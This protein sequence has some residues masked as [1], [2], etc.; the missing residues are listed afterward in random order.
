[1]CHIHDSIRIQPVKFYLEI[2]INCYI[3]GDLE[4]IGISILY[5]ITGIYPLLCCPC[6]ESSVLTQIYFSFSV[7]AYAAATLQYY[8]H[9]TFWLSKVK[10]G[11]EL[12]SSMNVRAVIHLRTICTYANGFFFYCS[13]VCSCNFPCFFCF[14]SQSLESKKKKDMIDQLR[15]KER[16]ALA[17]FVACEMLLAYD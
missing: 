7:L 10:K 1:M 14:H 8:S 3:H 17:F 4:N 11:T 12:I 5:L 9:F 6:Q 16:F 15:S 2:S 13:F